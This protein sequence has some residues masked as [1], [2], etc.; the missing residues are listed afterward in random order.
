MKDNTTVPLK[1]PKYLSSGTYGCVYNPSLYC[2]DEEKNENINPETGI[3]KFY[4]DKVSKLMYRSRAEQELDVYKKLSNI[5]DFEDFYL[6]MPDMC[7]IL[8]KSINYRQ[9]DRC[10]L[11]PRVFTNNYKLLIM[12]N[13]GVQINN[14][15]HT[16]FKNKTNAQHFIFEYFRMLFG[17]KKLV[18]HEIIHFD[19]RPHNILFNLETEKLSFIDFSVATNFRELN[20]KFNRYFFFHS[21]PDLTLNETFIPRYN[22]SIIASILNVG[23]PTPS[24]K[25][26]SY[27]TIKNVGNTIVILTTLLK[28]AFNYYNSSISAYYMSNIVKMYTHFAINIHRRSK[29]MEEYDIKQRSTVDLYMYMF[30]FL[31]FLHKNE[32]LK[33][34]TL[35]EIRD[36]YNIVYKCINPNVFERNSVD[37]TIED[38]IVFFNKHN[39]IKSNMDY[40]EK[41]KKY[42]GNID[43]SKPIIEKIT[44]KKAKDIVKKAEA[45]MEKAIENNIKKT[46]N[47]TSS[48]RSSSGKKSVIIKK[49]T[50]KKEKQS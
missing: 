1:S 16:Y 33:H 35:D 31:Q 9:T 2:D 28:D 36:L 18:E 30:T 14:I 39:W 41:N 29:V 24:K 15:P 49:R 22:S 50:K 44:K 11:L 43:R 46:I 10:T 42:M 4:K 19:L 25:M 26:L 27:F 6:G 38:F 48:H 47:K 7:N 34:L 40:I 12:K 5:P 3:P 21:P 32:L 37:D 20:Y 23:A 13:G 17:I 8:P 45:E